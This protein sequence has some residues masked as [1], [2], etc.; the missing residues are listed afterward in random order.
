MLGTGGPSKEEPIE[1]SGEPP[2]SFQ[3]WTSAGCAWP[4][5]QSRGLLF[6][7]ERGSAGPRPEAFG[8]DLSTLY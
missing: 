7:V 3:A 6:S 1:R 4:L 2:S 8:F 5:G